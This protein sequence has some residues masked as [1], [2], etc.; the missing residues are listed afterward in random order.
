MLIQTIPLHVRHV[1]P[2]LHLLFSQPS[3]VAIFNCN[4]YGVGSYVSEAGWAAQFLP[5]GKNQKAQRSCAG[6]Q[7]KIATNLLTF[8]NRLLRAQHNKVVPVAVFDCNPYEVGSYATLGLR[9][10]I[11]TEGRLAIKD[12][13]QPVDIRQQATSC[14][15]Q[16]RCVGSNL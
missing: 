8:V 7:S 5:F 14:P 15:T 4:P 10:K 13:Y 12:C 9:S 16:L 11:A 3:L 2:M 6:L 1:L